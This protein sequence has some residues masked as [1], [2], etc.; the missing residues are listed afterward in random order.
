MMART[1]P[2]RWVACQLAGS[3]S[4]VGIRMP[5]T[6]FEGKRKLSQNRNEADRSG[7]A[8]GLTASDRPSDRALGSLIA[9]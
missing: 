8:A 5:V 2:S 1:P 9:T 7:V 6:R 3:R 4:V